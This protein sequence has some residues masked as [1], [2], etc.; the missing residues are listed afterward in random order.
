VT[1][2]T[3]MSTAQRFAWLDGLSTIAMCIA[4]LAL[5]PA[6]QA[7]TWGVAVRI[8]IVTAVC[9]VAFY[10]NDLYNFEAPHDFAQLFSRLCRALGVSALVLAGGYLMFPDMIVG[11][12]L[13]S[14]ALLLTLLAVLSL[15]VVV[16]AL[17]K[18]PPFSERVLI[19]GGGRFAGELARQIETRPDL[20]LRVVGCLTP[21]AGPLATPRVG[22]YG[23]VGEVV[24]RLRPDRIVVAMPD[25]RG[26]LPV[27][28]LLSC[29]FRGIEIEEG[30]RVFERLTGRLAVEALSPST[31]VFGDGFRVS[32]LQRALK[33]VMSLAA[34]IVAAPA[35]AAIAV[36]IK[37]ES[38]RPAFFIQD[39]V[40]CG[41]SGSVW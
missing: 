19:L 18:R 5:L 24:R 25:R 38:R 16:Y 39:R 26:N 12:N 36:A 29:R 10:Y 28:D 41:A 22:G 23:D 8:A 20:A 37:L 31:L 9:I 3:M 21:T 17:A 15:R 33:R 2:V 35:L 14:Y 32:R 7:A 27:S 1:L 4:A 34:L 13:A 30:T 6:H 11:G 40:A